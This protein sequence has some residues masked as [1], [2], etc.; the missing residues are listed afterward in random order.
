MGDGYTNPDLVVSTERVAEH[1]DDDSTIPLTENTGDVFLYDTGHIPGSGQINW[2]EDLINLSKRP[3]GTRPLLWVVLILT[4]G[5]LLGGALILLVFYPES[6]SGIEQRIASFVPGT[7]DVGRSASGAGNAGDPV[8]G[9]LAADFTLKTLDGGEIT[10]SDLRGQP[11]LINFW[12]SWCGPCRREMPELVRVYANHK[13]KGFIVLA[14]NLTHQDA[15]PAVAA[16]V[17]EFRIPFPVL[18]DEAGEVTKLY[19]LRGIPVS[20]FVDRTGVVR[21]VYTGAMT[22]DQLDQF[23]AEIL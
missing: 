2:Q 9:Q 18:L 1:L 4:S 17:E 7:S 6:L 19:Q 23:V 15:L 8:P 22:G 16:F 3:R 5:L 13:D 10:L 11:V 21:R 14:L 12:A 20:V